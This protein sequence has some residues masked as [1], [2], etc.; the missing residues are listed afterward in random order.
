MSRLTKHEELDNLLNMKLSLWL[1]REHWYLWHLSPIIANTA[2]SSVTPCDTIILCIPFVD[3]KM[4]PR[5]ID[6]KHHAGGQATGNNARGTLRQAK[7]LALRPPSVADATWD[8]SMK[9]VPS[10]YLIKKW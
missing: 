5:C 1:P 4:R 3:E 6:E 8:A 9:L 2:N 10:G 7:W